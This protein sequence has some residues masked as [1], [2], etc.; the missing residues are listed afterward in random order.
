[1]ATVVV[2]ITVSVISSGG[3]VVVI[4]ILILIIV[5]ANKRIQ[6]SPSTSC[7]NNPIYEEPDRSHMN[8]DQTIPI[9]DNVAYS[10]TDF[11]ERQAN[12]M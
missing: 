1:M 4:V 7:V 10:M 3:I 2:I 11:K 5:R 8:T 12:S 6:N 9:S